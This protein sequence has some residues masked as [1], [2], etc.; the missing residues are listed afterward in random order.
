M[1]YGWQPF[2]PEVT[3]P[4]SPQPG[5]KVVTAWFAD[6]AWNVSPPATTTINLA[7]DGATI[8]PGGVIQY[9][10]SLRTGQSMMIGVHP[11]AGDPDLYVWM[12]GHVGLPD[13]WSNAPEGDDRVTFVAPVDGVYLIEVHGYTAAVFD[14]DLAPQSN[15]GSESIREDKP[16]PAAP[17][18]VDWPD[19]T[20]EPAPGFR[21]YLPVV[22]RG[23]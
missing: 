12:P 17:V 16:L 9:R 3:W 13:W 22:E 19:A 1:R 21:V 2:A 5:V 14:L 18:V 6:A 7:A 11:R 4:L 20:F 23:R 10:H 8:N 15:L